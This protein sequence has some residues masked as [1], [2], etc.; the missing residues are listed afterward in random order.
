LKATSRENVAKD[1]RRSMEGSD[2]NNNGMGKYPRYDSNDNVFIAVSFFKFR[3][4]KVE[5]NFKESFIDVEIVRK[6]SHEF[7]DLGGSDNIYRVPVIKRK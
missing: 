5:C 1:K 6:I 4:C 2:F 7:D 3:L